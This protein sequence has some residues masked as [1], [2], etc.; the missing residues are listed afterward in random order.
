MGSFRGMA[1]ERK[2]W[3]MSE[4]C[5]E[6]A[7]HGEELGIRYGWKADE[8]TLFDGKPSW[9]LYVDLP[10]GQVSFHSPAR[11]EGPDYPGDWDGVKASAERVIAFCESVLSVTTEKPS[12]L[13]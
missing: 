4:L 3:S 5:K 7:Q 9:V 2:S 1:Y 13:F 10:N 12:E 11:G 8:K 6:L